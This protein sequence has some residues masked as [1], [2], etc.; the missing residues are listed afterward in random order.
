MLHWSFNFSH[1]IPVI[2]PVLWIIRELS[3]QTTTLPISGHMHCRRFTQP[4]GRPPL[5]STV[6]SLSGQFPTLQRVGGRNF[7][8]GDLTEANSDFGCYPTR[9]KAG[10]TGPLCSHKILVATSEW[11]FKCNGDHWLMSFLP[12]GFIGYIPCMF[13]NEHRW[14]R[15]V[16][17]AILC[18][19]LT[20]TG[21]T[22]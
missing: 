21:Q 16:I 1:L 3:K 6:V 10:T 20:A 14:S 15:L 2:T 4:Y 19:T 7:T 22:T 11:I 9:S 18:S 5:H 17:V 8:C 13:L 12:T